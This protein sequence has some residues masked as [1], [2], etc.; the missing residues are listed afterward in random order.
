MNLNFKQRQTPRGV[1]ALSVAIA[2]GRAFERIGKTT[3]LGYKT[4]DY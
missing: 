4:A 2:M 1:I 3:P